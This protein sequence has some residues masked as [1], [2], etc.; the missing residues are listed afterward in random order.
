MRKTV[1]LPVKMEVQNDIKQKMACHN[2]SISPHFK[3]LIWQI[4]NYF[5]SQLPFKKLHI[6]NN[7]LGDYRERNLS[8]N[9]DNII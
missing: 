7:V 4:G 3:V 1:H 9:N 6:V 2:D 5:Q 8:F